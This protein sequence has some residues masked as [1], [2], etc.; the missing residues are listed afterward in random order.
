MEI[1]NLII[2]QAWFDRIMSGNK[3]QEFRDIKPTTQ[4]RYCE[5]DKEGYCIERNGEIVP[6]H[7]DAIRFCVG[8][9]KDRDTALVRVKDAHIELVEDENGALITD[10]YKGEEYNVAQ[11]VYD[12]GERIY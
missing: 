2:T 7:Y 3:K 4:R 9:R 6:R 5:V 8:Y 12:L 11:A 1:L 10:Y